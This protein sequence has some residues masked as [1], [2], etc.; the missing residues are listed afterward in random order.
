MKRQTASRIFWAAV[1][2]ITTLLALFVGAY[3]FI[4]SGGVQMQTTA[5]PLPFE[6]TIARMALHASYRSEA[7]KKNPLA[8]NDGNMVSEA[9]FYRDN[10]ARC[11][12]LPGRLAP[13]FAKTMFPPPPQLFDAR[14]MVTNNPE[15][16]TFWKITN[17]IR[18]SGMPGFVGVLS[19]EQR[20]QIAMLL[21]HA[22]KLSSS[23]RLALTQAR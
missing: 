12:G 10:C 21:S 9:K 8:L 13:S 20:W 7:G 6:K 3:V 5:V 18:L 19:D 22:D 11:H 14:Q 16:V 15:G 2:A 17:G 1:G 4:N 23:E